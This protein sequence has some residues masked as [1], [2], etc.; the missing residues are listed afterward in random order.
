MLLDEFLEVWGNDEN[1]PL[2]I[3]QEGTGYVPY[4]Y[5]NDSSMWIV[6]SS[7]KNHEVLSIDLYE[8]DDKESDERCFVEVVI[9]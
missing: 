9:A 6:D 1:G 8:N 4:F 3:V 7:W 5:D 2:E